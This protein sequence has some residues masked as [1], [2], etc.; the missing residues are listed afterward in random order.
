MDFSAPKKAYKPHHF[1][2]TVYLSLFITVA[3]LKKTLNQ[4][5]RSQCEWGY[6]KY[7]YCLGLIIVP[8]IKIT[9]MKLDFTKIFTSSA[10]I[11]YKNIT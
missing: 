1:G 5:G 6:E 7:K 2:G 9:H 4:P 10:M 3:I 8:K 11:L